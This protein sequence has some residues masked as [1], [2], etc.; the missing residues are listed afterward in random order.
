MSDAGQPEPAKPTDA[1]SPE[2][3][4]PRRR[5]KLLIGIGAGILVVIIAVVAVMALTS[6][7]SRYVSADRSWS[8]SFAGSP[9]VTHAE[10]GA[11]LVRWQQDSTS[12]SVR[13]SP[14]AATVSAANVDTV[15]NQALDAGSNALSGTIVHATAPLTVGG[16]HALGQTFTI[17]G[18]TTIHEVVFVR[19]RTSYV[20]ILTDA[21]ASQ[22]RDFVESFSFS[23]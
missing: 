15:L 18:P 8:V 23:N 19:G 20:L 11:Q 10:N 21:S 7:S 14:H 4:P 16:V 5:R 22:D 3:A 2:S 6:G 17:S 12:Q 13:T 9:T 1:A